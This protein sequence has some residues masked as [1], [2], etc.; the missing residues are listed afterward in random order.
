MQ[1]LVDCSAPV[2]LTQPVRHRGVLAGKY[3]CH[4]FEMPL[5]AHRTNAAKA[6]LMLSYELLAVEVAHLRQT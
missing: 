1:Q 5:D 6:R 2:E 4:G 3:R